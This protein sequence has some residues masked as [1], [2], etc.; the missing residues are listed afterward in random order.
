MDSKQLAEA[1]WV[2]VVERERRSERK[3]ISSKETL[4]GQRKVTREIFETTD[5]PYVILSCGHE[6]RGA[7]FDA[8]GKD[9]ARVKC[10]RCADQSIGCFSGNTTGSV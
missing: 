10:W 6:V 3:L 8:R 7:D 2:D 9:R 5:E 1:P 4:Y